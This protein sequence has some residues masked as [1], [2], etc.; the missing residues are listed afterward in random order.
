MSE[1]KV[2]RALRGLRAAG[3]V[4]ADVLLIVADSLQVRVRDQEIDFVQQAQSR[5][6]GL[7]AFVEGSGGLQVATTST[8]DL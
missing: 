2:E 1:Q 4:D 8:R 3:A 5:S 7:R 6:L